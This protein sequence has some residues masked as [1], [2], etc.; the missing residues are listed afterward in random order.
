MKPKLKSFFGYFIA[1]LMVPVVFITLMGMM[2]LAEGLVKA[3]GVVISPWFT[4]GEIARSLTHGTYETLIHR[5]VFD[6]LIG[7]RKSGFVQ[8]VWTPASL[9]PETIVED[10]DFNGDGQA[11]FQVTLHSGNK[12]AAWKPYSDLAYGME[13]PYAIGDGLGVR[14]NL[15]NR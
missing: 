15:K 4:G 7:Q 12:T 5:P 13:G 11:D 8:V 2:P 1:A 9:L 6:G 10:I 14:I 3:S